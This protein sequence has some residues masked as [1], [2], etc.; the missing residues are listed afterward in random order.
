[1]KTVTKPG[2]CISVD[3]MEA[4]NPGLIAQLKG[5]PTKDRY[6]YATIFVDHF[7]DFTFVFLQKTLTSAETILA[8]EAFKAFSRSHGVNIKHYHADNLRKRDSRDM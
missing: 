4:A 5:T 8:W 7:S 2:Q 1:L 6:R 3:Q